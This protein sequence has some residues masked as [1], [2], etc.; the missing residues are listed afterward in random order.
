MKSDRKNKTLL[1]RER[2]RMCNPMLGAAYVSMSMS[3]LFHR[4]FIPFFRKQEGLAPLLNF[5][6]KVKHKY[7]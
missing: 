6:Q 5:I 1:E 4:V 3:C 7:K 2:K